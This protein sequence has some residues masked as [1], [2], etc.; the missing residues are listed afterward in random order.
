MAILCKA[1]RLSPARLARGGIGAAQAAERWEA[2]VVEDDVKTVD[3]VEL[4]DVLT[5]M[6]V[7]TNVAED[8]KLGADGGCW[9]CDGRV[10][11]K[12][13]GVWRLEEIER[14]AVADVRRD[15]DWSKTAEFLASSEG[16]DFKE[17]PCGSVWEYEFKTEEDGSVP[18]LAFRLFGFV[19]RPSVCEAVP[20]AFTLNTSMHCWQAQGCPRGARDDTESV[21]LG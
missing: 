13:E 16:M 12:D 14:L 11:G 4:V 17:V 5:S 1:G 15:N 3:G 7:G 10:G 6:A 20:F 18:K 21:P 2:N 9:F 8:D 19:A